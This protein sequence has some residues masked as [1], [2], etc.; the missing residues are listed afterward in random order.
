MDSPQ[1]VVMFAEINAKLVSLPTIEERLTTLESK[2]DTPELIAN[3]H[4]P[5]HNWHNNE[6]PP[7]PDSQYL[8]NIKIDVPTFDGINGP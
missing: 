6:V 2:S 1:I 5:G 7:N 4:I 3:G 8:K